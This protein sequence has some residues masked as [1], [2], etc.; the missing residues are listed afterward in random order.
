MRIAFK[1]QDGQVPT[2]P[3]PEGGC[4]LFDEEGRNVLGLTKNRDPIYVPIFDLVGEP[5]QIKAAILKRVTLLEELVIDHPY[6]YLIVRT[7]TP[8]RCSLGIV[9]TKVPLTPH[10]G[11]GRQSPCLDPF[12]TDL[13]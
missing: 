5:A 1:L 10:S 12:I 2:F 7:S 3:Y 4:Y 9:C 11:R 6:I 13:L 8:E